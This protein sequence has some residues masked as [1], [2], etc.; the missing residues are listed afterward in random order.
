MQN[1]PTQLFFLFAAIYLVFYLEMHWTPSST[2][3]KLS[4]IPIMMKLTKKYKDLIKIYT[5]KMK[6]LSKFTQN[7]EALVKTLFFILP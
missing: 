7:I 6:F 2:T 5:K 1:N 3:F 4:F